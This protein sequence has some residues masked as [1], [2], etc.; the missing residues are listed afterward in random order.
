MTY[1]IYNFFISSKIIE[2]E[3]TIIIELFAAE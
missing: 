3:F 1:N 2:I